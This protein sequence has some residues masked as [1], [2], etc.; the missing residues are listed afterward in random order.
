[1]DNVQIYDSYINLPSTQTREV[2]NWNEVSRHEEAWILPD[3]VTKSRLP[4]KAVCQG[5]PW[6]VE[7][8]ISSQS[9]AT[10]FLYGFIPF[11]RYEF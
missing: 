4:R 7:T 2:M 6:S 5:E 11:S 10:L 1:M 9:P 3:S 8:V